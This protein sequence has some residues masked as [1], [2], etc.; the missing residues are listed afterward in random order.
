[1]LYVT[2]KDCAFCAEIVGGTRDLN[3][4]Q[5]I[6]RV[7][8]MLGLRFPCGPALEELALQ[9]TKPIP[10]RKVKSEDGFIHLSGVENMARKLFAES[11]NG[12]YTAAFVL[13]YLSLAVISM[14]LALRTRF[15]ES[16]PI[17]YAGGVMSNAC[18]KQ[19]VLEKI[20]NAYF[21][22]PAYS[23]DNSAGIALLT[24][25]RYKGNF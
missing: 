4:G 20:K 2:P 9:N 18:I 5:L 22:R 23:S 3:A 11:K 8:V 24:E 15:G 19:R 17:V 14:S 25:E 10:R 7:G 6:D 12:A 16:L 21:A 1:M 13:E